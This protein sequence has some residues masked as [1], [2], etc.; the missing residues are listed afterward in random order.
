[1]KRGRFR[2]LTDDEVRDELKRKWIQ[3]RMN[4]GSVI[5]NV[6]C[7]VCQ[8]RASLSS[9]TLRCVYCNVV[10]H[11]NC[12]MGKYPRAVVEDTKKWICF[13]CI[14]YLDDSRLRYEEE[15][16]ELANHERKVQSQIIIA[17]HWRRYKCRS[18]YIR[19]YNIVVRLQITYHVKHRKRD[20]MLSLQEKLRP[21]KVRLIKCHNI[22]VIDRDAHKR[23]PGAPSPS[24]ENNLIRREHQF[25][26][27]VTVVDFNHG[28][29]NQTWRIN[30]NHFFTHSPPD[31]PFNLRCDERMMIGGVSGFHTIVITLFQAG[32]G[33]NHLIGQ[34]HVELGANFVWRRGG[35][36]HLE[37]GPSEFTIKDYSGME[38][39]ADD[40]SP[41][42]GS[43]EFEI[44]T[45]HGMSFECGHC[46]GTSLEDMLRTLGRLPSYSGFNIETPSSNR[47]TKKQE[48]SVSTVSSGS[49]QFPMKRIWIAIAEGHLYAYSHFGDQ[50]KLS[51]TLAE[52]TVNYEFRD[53]NVVF[54]MIRNGYPEFSFYPVTVGDTLRW[55]CAFLASLR[56]QM[57]IAAAAMMSKST[58]PFA[59]GNRE[60]VE[61]LAASPSSSGIVHALTHSS[62][63]RV[64]DMR[65]LVDDLIA[66]EAKLMSQKGYRQHLAAINGVRGMFAYSDGHAKRF[67]STDFTAIQ[68]VLDAS[69]TMA[70]SSRPSAIQSTVSAD[71]GSTGGDSL[72]SSH[73]NGNGGF[74]SRV[75]SSSDVSSVVA[76]PQSS[77]GKQPAKSS[78]P[79][80]MSMRP[81]AWAT[82]EETAP[83]PKNPIQ[84]LWE[85]LDIPELIAS[86]FS[87]QYA[88]NAAA[89]AAIAAREAAD[90]APPTIS[91]VPHLPAIPISEHAGGR[92]GK[93]RAIPTTMKERALN[94]GVAP[95]GKNN[96]VP[97]TSA[98]TDAS[99]GGG[100]ST[101]EPMSGRVMSSGR[102]QS[103]R[104]T[105]TGGFDPLF[106]KEVRDAFSHK[107]MEE[108]EY[109][110]MVDNNRYQ[111]LGQ[112][113]VQNMLT[114]MAQS[115]L[116][117]AGT[118]RSSP[119]GGMLSPTS[120]PASPV[121]LS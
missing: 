110:E 69:H 52:F 49:F 20:F 73:H 108:S 103:R 33:R 66:M 106:S 67:G 62:V 118:K 120:G 70:G 75:R 95:P 47:Q 58:V 65:S 40:R 53:G 117:P 12:F 37:F 81:G 84:E 113:F 8:C 51:I 121:K 25:F 32:S 101:G 27:V 97:I 90:N 4:D 74:V 55:K 60:Q 42:C 24:K 28:D 76:S 107:I 99:N 63:N 5:Y 71:D 80:R 46:Y 72:S 19:F 15:Y 22:Q 16:W 48:G 31:V 114:T 92:R 45:Y 57:P 10:C 115:K 102:R 64:F 77:P 6:N 2:P 17:K 94:G 89:A 14:D 41:P 61:E 39:R 3:P 34:V 36:F 85:E 105:G 11:Y 109:D 38:L 56:Y 98:R 86:P 44:T 100:G 30:S 119:T 59:S 1:M 18:F 7:D 78:Q 21:I 116:R 35:K 83:P 104:G 23:R 26:F 9:E 87:P 96:P 79:R 50:L 91:S 68:Q 88:T 112:N 29:F 13:H 82:E 111:S 93:S 43:L 54:K